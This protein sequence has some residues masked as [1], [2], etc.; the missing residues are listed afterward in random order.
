MMAVMV[1]GGNE[2]R[3]RPALDQEAGKQLPAHVIGNAHHGHDGQDQK[4][5]PIMDRDQEDEQW[6]HKGP[7]D[8]FDGVEAHGCPGGRRPAGMMNS[9]SSPEKAR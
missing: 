2:P 9:M 1:T 4:Q 3:A 5:P 6:D 8:R 7:G